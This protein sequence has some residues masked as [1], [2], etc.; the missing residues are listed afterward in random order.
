MKRFTFG[1]PEK[2]VPSRFCDGFRYVET[3]VNQFRPGFG[4]RRQ[5]RPGSLFRHQQGLRD[6]F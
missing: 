1:M 3:D 5:P 4:H 6:V 2:M